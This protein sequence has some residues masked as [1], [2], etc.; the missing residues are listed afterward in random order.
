MAADRARDG[1]RTEATAT[2][3]F[4]VPVPVSVFVFP[5]ITFSSLYSR[6]PLDQSV[7]EALSYA[8]QRLGHIFLY[9]RHKSVAWQE[10]R[11]IRL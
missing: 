11:L 8:S 3:I 1:S 4:S 9:H 7:L 2:P 10:T 6:V 5:E